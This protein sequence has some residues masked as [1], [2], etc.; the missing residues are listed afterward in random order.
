MTF[1]LVGLIGTG[2]HYLTLIVLVETVG[3]DP[4]RATTAGFVIGAL[5]NYWLNHRFTFESNKAHRDAGPKFFFIAT[6]TGF[7][8]SL[9]VYAGVDLMGGNYL[10]V[11][12]GVTAVVFLANFGLN[13]LWTFREAHAR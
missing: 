5:V 1:A 11:Q 9:L 13:S 3:V 2:A 12:I 6:L 8:N 7:L 10:L 4:V